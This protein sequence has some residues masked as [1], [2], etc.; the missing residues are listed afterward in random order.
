MKRRIPR[1]IRKSPPIIEI[2]LRY[3][4]NF[5]I[6]FDAEPIPAAIMR[7]GIASPREKTE[8]RNAPCPTVAVVV[9]SVRM[10]P[11]IGPTHGV[12]PK[13]NVAPKIVELS[14]L[15]GFNAFIFPIL[16]STFRN[17]S[18]RTPIMKSPKNIT[19]IPP[20][21]E[22]QIRYWT[23]AEPTSPKRLP[24]SIKIKLNPII[25]KR[26]LKNIFCRA[27]FNFSGS[28]KSCAETP[29]INP[30]YPGTRGSVQGARKVRMPAINAGIMRDNSIIIFC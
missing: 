1:K 13:A 8:R 21:R 17:G 11:R 24:S 19:K 2:I 20:I 29:L 26:P 4:F 6:Y 27:D 18:R 30:K 22:S 28:C 25:N 14:G 10:D 12:Q 9:A 15:P 23:R 3:L 7:N 5:E 16:F